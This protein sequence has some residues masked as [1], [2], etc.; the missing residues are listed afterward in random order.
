MDMSSDGNRLILGSYGN[1]S[2]GNRAG[3]IRF[4]DWNSSTQFWQN[5]G[6][7]SGQFADQRLG[8]NVCISGDGQYAAAN[9]YELW[10]GGM[11]FYRVLGGNVTVQEDFPYPCNSCEFGV[12][13]DLNYNGSVLV[14]NTFYDPE[15]GPISDGTALAFQTHT[16]AACEDENACNYGILAPCEYA[17]CTCE[18]ITSISFGGDAYPVEAFA[19]RCWFKSNLKSQLYADG[20]PIPYAT[21]GQEWSDASDA[22]RHVCPS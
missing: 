11:Q 3:Q 15:S 14:A 16:V 20:S 8:E 10:N 5:I 19:G 7:I 9:Q 12:A 13:V 21:N 1:D 17:S 4:F 22:L 18:D 6:V 2:G